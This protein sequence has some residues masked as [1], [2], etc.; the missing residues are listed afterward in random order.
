MKYLQESADEVGQSNSHFSL[1]QEI[2][3]RSE[4]NISMKDQI[5]RM[6]PEINHMINTRAMKWVLEIQLPISDVPLAIKLIHAVN[7]FQDFVYIDWTLV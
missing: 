2:L 4:T 1:V 5:L 6:I 7:E 3:L